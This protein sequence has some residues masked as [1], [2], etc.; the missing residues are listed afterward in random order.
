MF[1]KIK[2]D[3]LK[4]LRCGHEWIPRK[5]EIRICPSCKSAWWDKPK[6]VRRILN[7]LEEQHSKHRKKF[8]TSI[9]PEST[10]IDFESARKMS[11]VEDRAWKIKT[12]HL[13]KDKK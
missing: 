7:K 4:C 5:T 10:N 6:Q 12:R 11:K 13:P 3:E 8:N 2:I 9:R 1:M